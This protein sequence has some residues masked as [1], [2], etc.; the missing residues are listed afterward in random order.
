MKLIKY[1]FL[2]SLSALLSAQICV[3]PV[4]AQQVNRQEMASQIA[5]KESLRL[6][7]FN[8]LIS[9]RAGKLVSTENLEKRISKITKLTYMSVPASVVGGAVSSQAKVLGE[10]FKSVLAPIT[11][12][13][14]AVAASSVA[15]GEFSSQISTTSS[16]A[17]HLDQILEFSSKTSVQSYQKIIAPIV[18]KLVFKGSTELFNVLIGVGSLYGSFMYVFGDKQN[19]VAGDM[20]RSM[21]GYNRELRMNIDTLTKSLAA[22]YDIPADKQ[23]V[24]KE[25]LFNAMLIEAKRNGF[26]SDAE[27]SVDVLKLMA[28]NNII[29]TEQAIVA[30]NL[31]TIADQATEAQVGAEKRD[32]RK[33]LKQNVDT[34]IVLTAILEEIY[35]NGNLSSADK[36]NAKKMLVHAHA[37][38]NLINYNLA[39]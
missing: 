6:L 32:A 13:I 2:M 7:V 3:T 1:T 27:Y 31:K 10:V 4:L 26:K 15:V 23:A 16:K 21:F 20:A 34:V 14:K 30:N 28:K 33:E 8:S 17:I 19:N 12:L 11:A 24:F 18:A 35:E 37:N 22:V 9:S 38:L 5:P 25:K 36:A 39:N 29:T